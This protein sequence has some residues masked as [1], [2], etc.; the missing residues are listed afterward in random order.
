MTATTVKRNG[1]AGAYGDPA[2][3][4]FYVWDAFYKQGLIKGTGY[5][6]QWL[7]CDQRLKKYLMASCSESWEYDK[8]VLMGWRTYEIT[9]D[10]KPNQILCPEV[11][12]GIS[13]DDCLLCC[14]TSKQAKN[15]AI[16]AIGGKKV[17]YVEVG[18]SVNSVYNS[19]KRGN[20]PA[21]DPAIIA[22]Y[23]CGIVTSDRFESVELWRGPSPVDNEPIVLI[24]T[25]LS[26]SESK[27]SKNTKT[28]PMVQTF[29]LKQNE[30]PT[31]AIKSGGDES[32]CGKCPLR[33]YLVKNAL[34]AVA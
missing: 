5:T 28:G 16:P 30:K 31:D 3:V 25:G 17:C 33:P 13:C 22:D 2:N 21:V 6:K 32:I 24:A 26:R 8:A 18:K 9:T 34:K 10:I 19:W 29:I 12:R 14:G 7:K 1:R 23:M 20:I 4:P 11:S 15:I 27:Q